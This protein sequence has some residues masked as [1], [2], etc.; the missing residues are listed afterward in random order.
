[1]KFCIDSQIVVHAKLTSYMQH[2]VSTSFNL[3][4]SLPKVFPVL[5]SP[6]ENQDWSMTGRRQTC[7]ASLLTKTWWDFMCLIWHGD[8]CKRLFFKKSSLWS[9]YFAKV[10]EP[11]QKCLDRP[12]NIW[13]CPHPSWGPLW[14]DTPR[15]LE[16]VIASKIASP[17]Y[18]EDP[19]Y[20]T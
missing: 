12:K 6:P 2:Q 7:A 8:H 1:M 5:K 19:T 14:H 13:K 10:P 9:R 18:W 20:W 16:P 3:L 15:R 11:S 17:E 4:Q